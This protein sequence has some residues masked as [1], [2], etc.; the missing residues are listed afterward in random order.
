MSKNL[1]KSKE[2]ELKETIKELKSEI[3]KL[4]KEIKLLKENKEIP[5]KRPKRKK[6]SLEDWKREFHEHWVEKLKDKK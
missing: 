5:E 2:K 1:P 3:R 6:L 4:N